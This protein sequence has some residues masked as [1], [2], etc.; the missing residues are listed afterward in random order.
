MKLRT[1]YPI[2]SEDGKLFCMRRENEQGEVIL[3]SKNCALKFTDLQLQAL[4][5]S[6]KSQQRLKGSKKRNP[7]VVKLRQSC[8]M[9]TNVIRSDSPDDSFVQAAEPNRIE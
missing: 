5:P 9:A 1:D 8:D 6:L 4:N 2:Y 7:N 3:E